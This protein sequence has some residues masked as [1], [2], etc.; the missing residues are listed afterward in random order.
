[1]IFIELHHKYWC[2]I[3]MVNKL[4]K[5]KALIDNPK[6]SK[7]CKLKF[8]YIYT[9]LGKVYG[10]FS[11][12]LLGQFIKL[13]P[14]TSE[15]CI[16]LVRVILIIE[17][18]LSSINRIDDLRS[19]LNNISAKREAKYIV[20]FVAVYTLKMRKWFATSYLYCLPNLNQ[21]T[22][23]LKRWMTHITIKLPNKRLIFFISKKFEESVWIFSH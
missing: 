12:I 4:W 22:Y 16:V 18:W 17:F 15:E 21:N 19:I 10:K 13:K 5:C 11:S 3:R 7:L 1:M 8:L 6:M 14:G 23:H 2:N 20:I 9:S